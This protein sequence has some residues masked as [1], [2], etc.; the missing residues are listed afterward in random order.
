MWKRVWAYL[1]RR[2][3]WL[4]PQHPIAL[5]DAR[6]VHHEL[7]LFIRRLANPWTLLGYAAVIHGLMFI[8]RVIIYNYLNPALASTLL[9][10]VSPFLTPFGTPIATGLLHSILYWAML[11]GICNHTAHAITRERASG[12]W[13]LLLLTPFRPVDVL[14]AK[15]AVVWRTWV[16]VLQTL[17]IIRLVGL[18]VLPIAVASQ[19][20]REAPAFQTLDL[21]GVGVFLLQPYA[22]AVLALG[23]SALMAMLVRDPMWA[24]L[25]AYGVLGLGI[26]GLN[27]A[28]AGWLAFTSPIGGL[29]GILVP[30]GHWMP[31]VATSVPPLSQTA[32]A[33]QTAVL[34]LTLV[35]L[36]VALGI[37]AIRHAIRRGAEA[38]RPT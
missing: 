28:A 16:G 23:G 12:S 35:V 9:P 19:Q 36:P 13:T 37:L 11:I 20:T 24:R 29:A 17:T 7:P 8:F 32:Y 31:L 27:G 33:M 3:P 26:G 5:R 2:Y 10:V 22:E 25:A 18:L 34:A 38:V 1:Q 4:K 15:L 30:L 21:I 6:W 14:M